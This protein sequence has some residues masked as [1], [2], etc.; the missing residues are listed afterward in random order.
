MRR[1]SRKSWRLFLIK[2]RVRLLELIRS[3]RLVRRSLNSPI[4]KCQ[5]SWWR[6]S[7][8]N[9]CKEINSRFS[10]ASSI[11]RFNSS[12][13]TGPGLVIVQIATLQITLGRKFWSKITRNWLL[14][15]TTE[16][17]PTWTSVSKSF[18]SPT[19]MQATVQLPAVLTLQRATRASS[20]TYPEKEALLTLRQTEVLVDPQMAAEL[21]PM[22]EFSN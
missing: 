1:N 7:R 9:R 14:E 13:I 5:L 17:A 2:N 19:K 11:H 6:F 21:D 15:S 4:S 3:Y 22:I 12:R 18:K 16:R 20:L 10:L 8:V